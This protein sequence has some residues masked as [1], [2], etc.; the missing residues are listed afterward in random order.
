MKRT[1]IISILF[2]LIIVSCN[3]QKNENAISK[4]K[5]NQPKTNILV[6]KE[7]DDSGNLIKYDSTYS[8]YYSNI[9]NDN[10][11]RD[12]IMNQF[13]RSF[14]KQYLFSKD[15]FFNDFF[16]QDSLLNFDFYTKDFFLNRYQN[17]PQRM[18]Q[19]FMEMDSIKNLFYRE[20]FM[21]PQK[22]K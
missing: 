19:L 9:E 8:Y 6:N 14:N 20:Q 13:K 11:L 2:S 12:S 22:K 1:M 4:A 15:P 17:N 7:Y 18:N 16:F 5:D 3:G 21:E 10:L